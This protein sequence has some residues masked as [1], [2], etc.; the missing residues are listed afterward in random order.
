MAR[1]AKTASDDPS[2]IDQRVHLH[3]VSWSDYERLLEL[4]GDD[5][6]VRMTYLDGELGL[7]TPAQTHEQQKTRLA[8]LLEA[9]SDEAGVDLEGAGS[10]TLRSALRRRGLEPDECYFVGHAGRDATAPDLAIEV[11]WTSGG[12]DKLTVYAGLGVREVW[13]WK[14]GSLT[15]HALRQDGDERTSRSEILPALD[16]ELIGRHMVADTTQS[17][18]VRDLRARMRSRLSS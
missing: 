1:S 14:D 3:G 5:P 13:I 7:M 16:P 6:G 18:A 10:W 12:F 11:V 8:R 4:R 2:L 17:Q 9:W 15:F